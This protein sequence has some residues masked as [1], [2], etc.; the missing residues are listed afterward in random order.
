LIFWPR[1][2]LP[3]APERKHTRHHAEQQ[4]VPPLKEKERAPENNMA[5]NSRNK[6]EGG[7]TQRLARDR[8]EDL[9]RCPKRV[10]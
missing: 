5:P 2:G 1:S 6:D 10:K 7:R 8:P 9:R 4:C 3:R